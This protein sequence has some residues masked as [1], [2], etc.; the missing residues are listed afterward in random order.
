MGAKG[1][2]RSVKQHDEWGLIL[3]DFTSKYGLT[4]ANLCK[5]AKGPVNTHY[6][7]TVETCIDYILVPNHLTN[8]ISLDDNPLNTS[9]HL[10][11][12]IAIN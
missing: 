5:E 11:V 3:H 7:P 6:G 4:P 1:G 8:S 12:K 10:L 9:D 2:P